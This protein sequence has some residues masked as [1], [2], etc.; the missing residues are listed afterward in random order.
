M[1]NS[2]RH[3]GTSINAWLEEELKD[4][5][6]QALFKRE[7]ERLALALRLQAMRTKRKLSIRAL[8]HRME[9]SASQVQRLLGDSVYKCTLETLI[10]FCV[11]TRCSL[12]DIFAMQ[13]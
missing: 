5:E 11:A 8:A 13:R 4:E 7:K 12:H 10:R 1:K 6:F 2:N 9:T 3:Q